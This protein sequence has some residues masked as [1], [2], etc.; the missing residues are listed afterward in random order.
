MFLRLIMITSFLFLAFVPYI[1]ATSLTDQNPTIIDTYHV[2][3]TGNGYEET[4]QLEGELLSTQSTYFAFVVAKITSK[5]ESN[6]EVELPG[7]FD[8]SLQ[9]IDI[10][11]NGTK[12]LLYKSSLNNDKKLYTHKLYTLQEMQLTSIPIPKDSFVH[13]KFQDNFSAHI[14]ITPHD[15]PVIVDVSDHAEEYIN[16]E[17]Y[18]PDGSLPKQQD[19]LIEPIHSIVASSK[20]EGST[21]IETLQYVSSMIHSN[22]LGTIHSRWRY[23][24]HS[25]ELLDSSWKE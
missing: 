21:V 6:W 1:E 20:D 11:N 3:L 24:D 4:I 16:M 18:Y 8:P 15:N 13:G 2:D 25:W 23:T 22:K 5:Q 7:G 10:T 17:I 19:I 9:F 14:Y 12:E